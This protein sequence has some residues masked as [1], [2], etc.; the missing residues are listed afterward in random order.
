MLSQALRSRSNVVS[1]PLKILQAMEVMTCWN[2]V[3][4]T[5]LCLKQEKLHFH[6]IHSF[7]EAAHNTVQTRIVMALTPCAA[8]VQP[9]LGA[10][11]TS[12]LQP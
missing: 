1:C 7:K 9:A 8:Q 5:H 11:S 12:A 10:C 3:R 6:L 4:Y 2:A